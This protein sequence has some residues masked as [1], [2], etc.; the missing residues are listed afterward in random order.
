MFAGKVYFL[1]FCFLVCSIY[2]V[3]A[4][5]S[6]TRRDYRH[7]QKLMSY[8]DAAKQVPQNHSLAKQKR[9][10]VQKQ[11]IFNQD[12]HRLQWRIGSAASEISLEQKGKSVEFVER[13]ENMSCMMQEKKMM[14]LLDSSIHPRFYQLVRCIEA[15]EAL[16]SYKHKQLEAEQVT[17]VRYR[18]PGHHWVESLESYPPF[19]RGEAQAIQLIFS[20]RPLFKAQGFQAA[21]EDWE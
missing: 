11:F 2:T 16:Y 7:Y 21:F 8:S 18:L 10:S 6:P 19:M 13:L 4:F 20:P 1:V 15:K 5:R 9:L 14:S 12:E 17:L 3:W